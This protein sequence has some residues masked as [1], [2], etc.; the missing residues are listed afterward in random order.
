MSTTSRKC[1]PPP[2][3]DFRLYS[4]HFRYDAGEDSD[5]YPETSCPFPESW[6][7]CEW[8]RIGDRS[9]FQDDRGKKAYTCDLKG[10]V[11]WSQPTPDKFEE[12]GGKEDLEDGHDVPFEWADQIFVQL[13]RYLSWTRDSYSWFAEWEEPDHIFQVLLGENETDA[14]NDE[15]LTKRTLYSSMCILHQ[16]WREAYR[17][18]HG[19]YCL[20][21]WANAQGDVW[22]PP[23]SSGDLFT[24]E[25]KPQNASTLKYR[26]GN[27]I[28]SRFLPPRTKD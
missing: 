17:N 4:I 3:G 6:K 1:R 22:L 28:L 18:D 10:L 11:L 13:K 12:S 9:Y 19:E 20:G 15:E 27:F 26:E 2:E 5:G 8:I 7:Q 16:V 23:P 21:F 24:E 25:F 14:E